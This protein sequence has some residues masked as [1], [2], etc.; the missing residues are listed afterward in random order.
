MLLQVKNET[1]HVLGDDAET[2]NMKTVKGRLKK[3]ENFL[4]KYLNNTWEILLKNILYSYLMWKHE[5]L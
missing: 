1:G 4:K 5:I 2:R 3:F